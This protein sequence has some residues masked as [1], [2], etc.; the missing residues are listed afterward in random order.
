MLSHRGVLI[1]ALA[2]QQ[3]GVWAIPVPAATTPDPKRLLRMSVISQAA[4]ARSQAPQTLDI[5]IDSKL[6]HVITGELQ[7]Q[8]FV[9]RRLV[10]EWRSGEMVVPFGR[11]LLRITVAPITVHH[12]QTPVSA[13]AR[14]VGDG[15]EY[16]LREHVVVV[17]AF[18]KR[19]LALAVSVPE[20]R[21]TLPDDA[22][23][24][25]ALSLDRFDWGDSDR[26]DLATFP[27]I[28]APADFPGTSAGYAV[29]DALLLDGDGF[30][31]LK[32]T[33][34]A[35]IGD[36]VAAGGSVCIR[37]EGPL[38]V[39]HAALLN[40]LAGAGSV[41]QFL[42]DEQRNLK[43]GFP[44]Q[45]SYARFRYGLGRAVILGNMPDPQEEI[46]T[47]RQLVILQKAAVDPAD[48]APPE[49]TP[50]T[51]VA[52]FL[53][54]MRVDQARHVR[55][56]GKW[57]FP[58]TTRATLDPFQPRRFG[59]KESPEEQQPS[60]L[61]TPQEVQGIPRWVVLSILAVFLTVIAPVDY[62]LLGA[63]RLRRLT[64]VFLAVV[65][66]AFT[67]GTI[68]IANR[69]MGSS[70]Y[71]TALVFVDLVQS[72]R[73]VRTSRFE[74]RFTATEQRTEATLR[75]TIYAPWQPRIESKLDSEELAQR[76]LASLRGRSG[77]ET[78]SRPDPYSDFYIA[79]ISTLEEQE[80]SASTGDLP[81]YEGRM[82]AT[83]VVRQQMRQW[84]PVVYR[85]TTFES[86]P[87][88]PPAV[89][90]NDA[91][92][93]TWGTAEGRAALVDSIIQVVPEAKVLLFNRGKIHLADRNGAF[94]TDQIRENQTDTMRFVEQKATGSDKSTTIHLN[95]PILK[96][97]GQA[98][99][100]HP[101]GLFSIVSQVAP[102][103][104]DLFEDLT[105]LDPSDPDEWLLAVIVR[106]DNEIQ[107]FRRL[108]RSG[109]Q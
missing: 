4:R 24:T 50:W 40:R 35:A 23:T 32:S 8:I 70:D 85:E 65:A 5:S 97:I 36:W 51:D 58:E 95:L 63:F 91:S 81:V 100:R 34:L 89:P 18:W 47:L 42:L 82:P 86:Q 71:R 109:V 13:I 106:Q 41:G 107:V 68:Q 103:G 45:Q 90:W 7:L 54:K 98:C 16:D 93:E 56:T 105:L 108:Y 28:L 39:A 73:P 11:Q 88:V 6:D 15:F 26:Y 62:F 101:R 92:P 9:G 10:Q 29:F 96:L 30:A 27:I 94:S 66:L 69:V 78:V 61:L 52:A 75:N 38:S 20:E 83:F 76:Q 67:V 49:Q 22:A 102:T 3:V 21:R 77:L 14:F 80:N 2:A 25:Q 53:W 64:W 43:P 74:L 33:Q 31:Q 17:P 87:V 55:Q 99:A 1:L 57:D 12:D 60:Q 19:S 84:S 59:P 72:D 46:D 44:G 48:A 79:P 104:A 37:P